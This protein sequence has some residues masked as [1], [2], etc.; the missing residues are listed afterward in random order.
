MAQ[1]VL[2]VIA[3]DRP[4]IVEAISKT[5]LAHGANWEA[6]RMV[7]LGGRFAGVLLVS[8]EDG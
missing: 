6:S 7:R 2:T 1:L 8:V 4:G 3:P 5:A